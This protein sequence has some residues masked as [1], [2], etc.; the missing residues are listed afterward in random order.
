VIGA[1][2]GNKTHSLENY[3]FYRLMKR[4][5]YYLGL[6]YLPLKSTAAVESED[7]CVDCLRSS[8]SV[9]LKAI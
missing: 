3:L 4:S 7:L 9:P 8:Y 5:V 1:G 6:L 2:I